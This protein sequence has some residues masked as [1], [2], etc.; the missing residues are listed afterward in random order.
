MTFRNCRGKR[1]KAAFV[2]IVA[3]HPVRTRQHGGR[4]RRL[5]RRQSVDILRQGV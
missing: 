1:A 4:G 3:D 5:A 2:T